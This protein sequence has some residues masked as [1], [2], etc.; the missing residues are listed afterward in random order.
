MMALPDGMC[1][2]DFD[3]PSE[4]FVGIRVFATRLCIYTEIGEDFFVSLVLASVGGW[5]MNHSLRLP[6][7][8]LERRNGHRFRL[9]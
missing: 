7:D 1:H 2:R 3:R 6:D 9:T 8:A 5:N 4:S